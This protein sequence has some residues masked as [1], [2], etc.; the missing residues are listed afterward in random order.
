[1]G[2][3][4][5]TLNN[6]LLDQYLND[7]NTHADLYESYV[8][9]TFNKLETDSAYLGKDIGYNAE[10][11]IYLLQDFVKEQPGVSATYLFD[12]DRHLIGEAG[13]E[14]DYRLLI[15]E[16]IKEKFFYEP[17]VW[18]H[19]EYDTYILY[20]KVISDSSQYIGFVVELDLLLNKISNNPTQEISI[21]NDFGQSV[22]QTL[23]GRKDDINEMSFRNQLLE[24]HEET[25]MDQSCFYSFKPVD[26]DGINL[27]LLYKN[28]QQEYSNT[29]RKFLLR[30]ILLSLFM[31]SFVLLQGWQLIKKLY[32]LFIHAVV[33]NNYKIKEFSS[34]KGELNKAIHW[35]DDVVKHY[36]ELNALK[37]ELIVLSHKIPEEGED[38]VKQEKPKKS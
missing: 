12:T 36:D 6:S 2:L 18:T 19:L 23:I 10:R 31:I 9:E 13:K 33:E 30:N 8:A 5:S 26:I 17:Y 22:T 14:H 7:A 29:I 35:V 34:I 15:E 11:D 27:F 3:N 24:G 38:I 37:E 20:Y 25:L 1:M 32:D 4:Y 16:E 28:S 21:I